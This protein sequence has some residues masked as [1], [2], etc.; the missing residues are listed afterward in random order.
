MN[1]KVIQIQQ[2]IENRP[3]NLFGGYCATFH[4]KL[5]QRHL[6]CGVVFNRT[7]DNHLVKFLK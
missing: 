2:Y 7:T 6:P 3:D 5:C 4:F 1:K